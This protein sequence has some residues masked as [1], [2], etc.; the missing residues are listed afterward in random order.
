MKV[1]LHIAFAL[2]FC[3]ITNQFILAQTDARITTLKSYFN[4][5]DIQTTIAIECDKIPY[6]NLSK[7]Q[8]QLFDNG[9]AVTSFSITKSSTP[10]TRR[11]VSAALVIDRSGSMGWGNPTGIDQAK[12]A[13]KAFV[14]FM[15][16]TTDEAT[17]ISFNHQITVD[18]SM[19]IDTLVLKYG[20]DNLLAYGNTAAWDAVITSLDEVNNNGANPVRAVIFL[21]DGEDNA[22]TST[23]QNIIDQAIKYN[24]RVYTIGLGTGINDADLS[25]IA[26]DTGGKYYKVPQPSDLQKIF[27]EIANKIRRDYDEHTI[28]YITPDAK[29]NQHT[30]SLQIIACGQTLSATRTQ[31][32]LGT[33]S[34][35]DNISVA[36]PTQITLEQNSPNPFSLSAGPTTIRF[37]LE[38]LNAKSKITLTV[39]DMLGREVSTLLNSNLS[40]GNYSVT[41]D[42]SKIPSGMYFYK[43]RTDS[44]TIV[45]KMICTK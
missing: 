1:L 30:L 41:F 37:S 27:L 34:S 40:D 8:L 42:A 23:V 32:V 38:G 36:S 31:S 21:T 6:Y 18:V 28:T 15:D 11:P 29:A 24:I 39:Y 2:M 5:S 35:T 20:I 7:D 26:D 13:S 10:A 9:K 44:R 4:R 45:K 43:L 16:G 22:S 12:V 14:D 33:V 17:L 25:Q 3:C 19:T